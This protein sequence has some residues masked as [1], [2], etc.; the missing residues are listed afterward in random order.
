MLHWKDN[1]SLSLFEREQAQLY[2]RQ[3]LVPLSPGFPAQ[4]GDK[5]VP[6]PAETPYKSHNSLGTYNTAISFHCT[7]Q[8]T[9]DRENTAELTTL[10]PQE[11]ALP[12]E[13]P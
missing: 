3:A 13:V 8:T 2:C 9:Y 12:K 6:V 4:T 7:L 11:S 1:L 10:E 5:M